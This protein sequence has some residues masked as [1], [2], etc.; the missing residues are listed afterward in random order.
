M[1]RLVFMIFNI[2]MLIAFALLL[3]MNTGLPADQHKQ[4][5]YWMAWYFDKASRFS[6]TAHDYIV[7]PVL[8]SGR[9]LNKSQQRLVKQRIEAALAESKTRS[10]HQ[11]CQE[12]EAEKEPELVKLLEKA[13][14]C[15]AEY[16]SV[17]S[18]ISHGSMKSPG[19]VP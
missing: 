18:R 6:N 16:S 2:P 14:E 19:H 3:R 13:A 10:Q 11:E 9:C 1:A 4:P 7:A 15:V 8:G 5:P 17:M 12:R